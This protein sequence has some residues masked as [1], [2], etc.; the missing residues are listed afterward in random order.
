MP[1]ADGVPSERDPALARN[2]ES[3]FVTLGLS[4]EGQATTVRASTSF[5]NSAPHFGHPYS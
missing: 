3:R 1:P 4:Q 2:S 5:S